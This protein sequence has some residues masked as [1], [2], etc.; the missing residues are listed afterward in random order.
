MPTNPVDPVVTDPNTPAADPNED[1]RAAIALDGPTVG[2]VA[3]LTAE[4]FEDTEFFVPYY[5][6]FEAHYTVDTLT[7][8]GTSPVAGAKG[9]ALKKGIKRIAD[10]N[11][12]DYDLVYIPGG[13]AAPA[14]LRED[15][16]ALDFLRT[17]VDTGRL[18]SSLCHGGRVL[19]AADVIRGRRIT[20]WRYTA[21]ELRAAGG[22]YVDEAGVEDGQFITGRQPSD[23]PR[24]LARIATRLQTT[25]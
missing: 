16:E 6:F 13:H 12:T 25:A 17:Y 5:R 20:G 11:P 21:D 3:I 15:K 22:I 18:T 19:A 10:A 9:I 8:P 2:R 4:G 1:N 7:P 24:M 23:M 14:I